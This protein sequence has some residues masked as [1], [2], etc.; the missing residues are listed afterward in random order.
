MSVVKGRFSSGGM[1]RG[2][3]D[4]KWPGEAEKLCVISGR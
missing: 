1:S 3:E 2:F 4:V